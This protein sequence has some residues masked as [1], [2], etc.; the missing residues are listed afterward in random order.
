VDVLEDI[1]PVIVD[2]QYVATE[3]S[4]RVLE[5]CVVP[6]HQSIVRADP[7]VVTNF[8][9]TRVY[10][11]SGVGFVEAKCRRGTLLCVKSSGLS[12]AV[13]ILR[14]DHS[15]HFSPCNVSSGLRLQMGVLRSGNDNLVAPVDNVH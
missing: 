1:G 11:A 5:E 8:N 4:A 13:S 6:H 12:R 2:G 9:T 10:Q 14:V 15:S 7:E 3:T